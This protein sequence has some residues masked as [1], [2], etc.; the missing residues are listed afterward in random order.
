M[1]SLY[2][3]PFDHRGSFIKL[4]GYSENNLSA[5]ALE[6]ISDY[7]HI[8]YEGFLNALKL[9]VPKES[10]AL[11][12]DERF[13]KRIHEEARALMLR[14]ILTV[15]RSGQ[16]E[17]DFEYGKAFGEHV[18][19]LVPEY[20]KALVRYNP[21]SDREMNKRQFV[22]L[23]TL[24]DF[25]KAKK[26]KFLFELLAVPV[27][28][29]LAE[30]GSEDA[31]ERGARFKVMSAAIAELQGVGVEPDVW[32]VEGLGDAEQMKAVVAAARAGSRA[33][34]GVVVLGRGENEDKVKTWLAVAA[35]IEGVIGFA[36]GRT[37][38]SEPLLQYHSRRITREEA[39]RAIASK[40]LDFV[41]WFEGARSA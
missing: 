34:V 41:R 30:A 35:S 9:G 33:G 16:D 2:I 28:A 7:K 12:V 21:R 37:V 22:R 17:F 4:F 8:I 23:K 32:K 5:D 13:G 24:S 20:V 14:R 10:A 11:L 1:T 6:K 15:E 31:Y 36:V 25:C 3:L 18:D 19:A 29:D 26:Y 27:Q 39:A 38:F 40:Y